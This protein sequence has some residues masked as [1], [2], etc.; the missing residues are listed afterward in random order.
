MPTTTLRRELIGTGIA[1]RYV[2][3]ASVTQAVGTES[4]NST[5]IDSHSIIFSGVFMGVNAFTN[6]VL[7]G[8]IG[9]L[10]IISFVSTVLEL[11]EP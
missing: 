3:E 10:H 4:N 8:L 7:T 9:T 11:T 6:L 1:S 2:G 5:L